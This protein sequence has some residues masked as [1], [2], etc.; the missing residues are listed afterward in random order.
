MRKRF[1]FA[2]DSHAN[3]RVTNTRK[4][5]GFAPDRHAN[6]RVT[7]MRKRFGF[8]P[9][10]HANDRVT[11][12]RNRFGFA[13]DRHANDR[14]T[15]MHKRFAHIAVLFVCIWTAS[16][17]SAPSE[18]ES[19][20]SV[21]ETRHQL[22]VLKKD[23]IWWVVNGSDM[24]WNFKNLHRMYATV[25]VYREGPVREL[26]YSLMPE[27]SA[28]RVDTP[29][30]P[31]GYLDFLDSEF[32][33]TMGMVILHKGKIVFEHYPRMQSYE[34]PIYWS[35]TKVF[36][37]A[38]VAILED[39]DLID[40]SAPID[41]YI[42]ELKDSDFSGIRIRNILDMATG[43]DCPEEYE[44]KNS[45]YYRY[46]VTVGD[47]YWDEKSPDNP[48][49]MIAKL[50]VG[51]H[52]PQGTSFSYSGVNTFVLAWLVEKVAGMPFQDALSRYIWSR[53][54][55]ES[56]AA[57]LAPRFGVPITHGGLLARLRDVARFGLLY[58]PS[59]KVVSDDKI[60]SN[61]HV[62]LISNG[63]NPDLLANAR[64]RSLA[65]DRVKHNV[66]QWDRVFTNNDFFK[67]GWAGQGLLVNP[68]RDLVAV[69]T[70][71]FKDDAHSETPPLSMLRKVLEG[72]FAKNL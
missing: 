1:G 41:R 57:F 33:T 4:R 54:G 68:D 48:Y 10:R 37:S 25:N 71:Y 69:Y 30:G 62:E 14:V 70:G 43:I 64:Y 63:G 15:N 31:M 9:D 53:M 27:I 36:V 32:S 66:Y 38:L 21:A 8:A 17:S 5:F 34:K 29:N 55:A 51:H 46:S 2:P 13:P 40:V 11:N 3:D 61:R 49:T 7:N 72:V 50:K 19:A 67:G 6:D 20:S 65:S 39:D 47:G 44:D 60:I 59:Y 28:F 52:A 35:V 26:T 24:A 58:T 18:F 22:S 23:D 42:P 12:M 45:C 56:D 16:V